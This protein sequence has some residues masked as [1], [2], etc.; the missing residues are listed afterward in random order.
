M[1][2][3]TLIKSWRFNLS[4]RLQ[5]KRI[6]HYQQIESEQRIKLNFY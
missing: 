4:N 5:A 3:T 6:A 1:V 2:N